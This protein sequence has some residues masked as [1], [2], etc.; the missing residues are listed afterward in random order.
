MQVI[1]G[2][3]KLSQLEEILS[4]SNVKDVLFVTGHH[5]VKSQ[6]FKK[7]INTLPFPFTIIHPPDGVLQV[8]GI[9]VISMPGA[10][11]AIG[12]GKAL[13]F[14]KGIIYQNKKPACFIAV[15]TTA[16]SGS[17]ATPIAVFY[18][19]KEKVSLDAPQLLPHLAILDTAL[20]NNLSQQ[21]RAISGADA[22]AQCIESIWN[23]NSSSLSEGYAIS[24][25]DLLWKGLLPFY[26]E[27]L[28]L[29]EVLWGAHLSGKA[30]ALTRTTGPHALAYH[31][32]AYYNVPHGQAVGLT[33]PVFFLYNA[34]EMVHAQLQKIYTVLQVQ[35]SEEAFDACRRFL[36]EM[37]L[38]T[39][40]KDLTL[41][42][43]D[44]D[45]WLSS[46]NQQ[47][48]ANNPVPF[49]A[50]KLKKLFLRYLC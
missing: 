10:V 22:V 17:E 34:E 35:T 37:N 21:Q 45:S 23:V 8:L 9:P 2:K 3:G 24:G 32:T 41:E 48:F 47:R 42:H 26:R 46:V 16:G 1:K 5:V 33:L 7:I 19:G 20:L 15:P 12:G 31:L 13:D 11:V 4:Q 44:I 39:T 30:I 40:L 28:N 49:H 50:E 43:I 25:L 14:A 38:A 6:F 29:D 18:S 36:K 27:G